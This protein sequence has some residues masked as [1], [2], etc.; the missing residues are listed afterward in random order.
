LLSIYN[1]KEV[2]DKINRMEGISGSLRSIV[3]KLTE[4]FTTKDRIEHIENQGFIGAQFAEPDSGPSE[5]GPYGKAG[6]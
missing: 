1:P 5:L 4:K 2:F 6:K 3:D